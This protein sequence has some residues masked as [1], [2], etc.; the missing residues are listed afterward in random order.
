MSEI[1]Y[2]YEVWQDDYVQAWGEAATA[3]EAMRE[4]DHYA[5][6]YGK[7]GPVLLKF[8]TRTEVDR[9]AILATPSGW[10][11]IATA[12]RDGTEVDVWCPSEWPSNKGGYRV[13]DSWWCR[14]R[15]RWATYGDGDIHWAHLPTHWMPPPEPPK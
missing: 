14:A 3:E 11:D 15:M 2:G 13:A 5:M 8:H 1:R 6:M 9:A 4:A 7:D 12:P 10:Q